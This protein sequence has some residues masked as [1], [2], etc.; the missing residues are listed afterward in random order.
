MSAVLPPRVG[1]GASVSVIC[2]RLDTAG[3]AITAIQV[4][5]SSLGRLSERNCRLAQL[6]APH[7]LLPA[8]PRTTMN[9]TPWTTSWVPG[10]RLRI[11]IAVTM[12]IRRTLSG[13]VPSAVAEPPED[14][15]AAAENR[16]DGLQQIW[17]SF[18]RNA[19]PT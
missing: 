12:R 1:E 13:T 19:P 9:T 11:C 10:G 3:E 7:V 5:S 15:C 4:S 8:T 14:Q 16:R 17:L 2:P 18:S 6:A